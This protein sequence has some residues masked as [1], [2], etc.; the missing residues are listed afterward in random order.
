MTKS[1]YFHKLKQEK[2]CDFGASLGS[3]VSIRTA[4]ILSETLS[5]KEMGKRGG[6]SEGGEGEAA[7]AAAA[8]TSG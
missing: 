5:Q 8:A 3:L 7:A 1:Q 6:G 2:G 4:G